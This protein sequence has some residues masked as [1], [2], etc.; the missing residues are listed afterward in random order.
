MHEQNPHF[1]MPAD[2]D[3]QVAADAF[4]MLAVATQNEIKPPAPKNQEGRGLVIGLPSGAIQVGC[5]EDLYKEQP[6]QQARI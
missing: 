6:R 3:V 5:L 4:R 2:A 1:D